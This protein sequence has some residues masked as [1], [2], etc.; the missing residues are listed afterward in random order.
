MNYTSK[1]IKKS[2]N[3]CIDDIS[4]HPEVYAK[5]PSKDFIRNRK[6][7]FDQMIK[8]ILAM[9]GKSLNGEL[10]DYFNMNISMPTVSAFVQQRD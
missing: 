8:C 10:M 2:L 6:L 4:A 9:S 5:N 1:T 3:K 7:P